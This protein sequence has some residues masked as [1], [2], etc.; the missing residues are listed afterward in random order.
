MN[1]Y[2]T[3]GILEDLAAG[4]SVLVVSASLTEAGHAHRLLLDQA[5]T[6]SGG[7]ADGFRWSWTNGGQWIRDE[8]TK[9]AATFVSIRSAMMDHLEPVVV[10]VNGYRRMVD[11]GVPVM[12][13]AFDR[14]RAIMAGRDVVVID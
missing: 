13:P 3:R 5:Y 6:V 12:G 8:S 4:R 14:L 9:T 2:V 1:R 10:V 7:N 11:T